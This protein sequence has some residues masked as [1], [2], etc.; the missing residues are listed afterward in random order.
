M[1]KK[2]PTTHKSGKNTPNSRSP[3]TGKRVPTE[4]KEESFKVEVERAMVSRRFLRKNQYWIEQATYEVRGRKVFGPGGSWPT[5][6][7]KD[8][9]ALLQDNEL[10]VKRSYGPSYRIVLC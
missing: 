5:M 8:L 7:K 9:T 6:T 3:G 10:V 2:T 1:A 4:K